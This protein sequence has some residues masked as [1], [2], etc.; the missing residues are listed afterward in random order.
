MVIGDILG[1]NV[2]FNCL[3]Q[4]SS[5]HYMSYVYDCVVVPNTDRGSIGTGPHRKNTYLTLF[6]F[7][8]QSLSELLPICMCRHNTGKYE[9]E[10][11]KKIKPVRGTKKVY[12]TNKYCFYYLFDIILFVTN[13]QTDIIMSITSHLYGH[14]FVQ[15]Q[16]LTY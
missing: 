1:H 13:R 7:Y 11:V 4:L 2:V 6:Q 9:H 8:L 14:Y 5:F 10:K 3:E 16:T 15:I 12:V